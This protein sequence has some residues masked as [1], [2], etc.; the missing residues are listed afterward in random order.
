MLPL[1]KTSGHYLRR[2]FLLLFIV[3]FDILVGQYHFIMMT[4]CGIISIPLP[5][6][7]WT[8]EIPLH[9]SMSPYHQPLY[10][11]GIFSEPSHKDYY[12]MARM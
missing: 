2:F 5:V 12:V 4:D 7:K 1:L 6:C 10:T 11:D 8:E 3:W 9:G